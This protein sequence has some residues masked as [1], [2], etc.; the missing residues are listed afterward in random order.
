MKT[1]NL[2]PSKVIIDV[3]DNIPDNYI[4]NCKD[5][6]LNKIDLFSIKNSPQDLISEDQYI[7][8]RF[9][10]L[11]S[12]IV[13]YINYYASLLPCKT[14]EYQICSSWVYVTKKNNI[15]NN[16]HSHINSNLSGVFYLTEGAPIIFTEKKQFEKLYPLYPG[17]KEDN[18]SDVNI[19]IKSKQLIIFPSYLEHAVKPN[20]IEGNRISIAFNAIPK[21]EIGN[22][23]S[24]LIIHEI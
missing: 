21:G 2:F 11:K 17:D 16:F 9:P 19:P 3:L 12:Q 15:S 6:I 1:L 10:K 5:I 22:K 13:K 4:E 18:S 24:K 23:T 20:K 7:L 8:N 14:V